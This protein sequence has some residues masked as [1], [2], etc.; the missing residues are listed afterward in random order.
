MAKPLIGLVVAVGAP[1]LLR[2]TD[3]LDLI[4]EIGLESGGNQGTPQHFGGVT[5]GDH[6]GRLIIGEIIPI[7]ARVEKIGHI[8][9]AKRRVRPS[10]R[11]SDGLQHDRAGPGIGRQRQGQKQHS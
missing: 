10:R 1:D 9:P 2:F 4:G 8:Q 5:E 6:Y 11:V 3:E 7:V